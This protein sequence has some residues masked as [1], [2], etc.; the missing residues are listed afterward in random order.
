MRAGAR[1]AANTLLVG[2]KAAHDD[3]LR[4]IFSTKPMS[5]SPPCAFVESL[6]EAQTR[7]PGMRQRVIGVN[8]RIVR[9]TFDAAGTAAANDELVDGFIDYVDDNIHAAGANTQIDF[10]N[11]VDDDGWVPEWIPAGPGNELRAYNS[12]VVTL[13]VEGLF[14]SP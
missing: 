14:G 12:T 9:G 7:T 1:E 13:T 3:A 5:I 4:Q 8:I 11:A 6:E 2:Y 10:S